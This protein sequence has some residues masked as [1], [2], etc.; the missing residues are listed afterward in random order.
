MRYFV[1]RNAAFTSRQRARRAER[2]REARAERGFMRM[3]ALSGTFFIL[4]VCFRGYGS[5]LVSWGGFWKERRDLEGEVRDGGTEGRREGE[6]SRRVY[7]HCETRIRGRGNWRSFCEAEVSAALARDSRPWMLRARDGR[8]GC[9]LFFP[10]GDPG[11]LD[12]RRGMHSSELR[13][14]MLMVCSRGS[15]QRGGGGGVWD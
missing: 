1:C 14:S 6:G 2:R 7:L 9:R 11:R 15:P 13:S 8:R 3:T 5:G 4:V 10:C 12:E